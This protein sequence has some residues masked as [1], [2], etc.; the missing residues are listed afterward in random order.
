MVSDSGPL[1]ISDYEREEGLFKILTLSAHLKVLK[2]GH[3]PQFL[4][5]DWDELLQS[6]GF[7]ATGAEGYLF[8]NLI[9]ACRTA[10]S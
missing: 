5:H 9:L 4:R 3:M 8:P 10:D 1:D 7:Q 2:P 6:A